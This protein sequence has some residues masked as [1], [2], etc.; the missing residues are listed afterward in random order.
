MAPWDRYTIAEAVRRV[1]ATTRG[2]ALYSELKALGWWFGNTRESIAR[3][4]R[5][6]EESPHRKRI[7]WLLS[8]LLD[9]ELDE[10]ERIA[11]EV[12]AS[13][14]PAPTPPVPTD[15]RVPTTTRDSRRGPPFVS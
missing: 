6:A 4:K 15:G 8:Q 2:A 13:T 10:L 9:L 12:P 7:K 5:H 3:A 11:A 14:A 1:A